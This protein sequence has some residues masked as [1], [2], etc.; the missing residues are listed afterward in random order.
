MLNL[1][2]TRL[3]EIQTF[4]L[5]YRERIEQAESELEVDLLEIQLNKLNEEEHDILKRCNAL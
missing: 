4:K 2:E 3:K 5:F 1:D